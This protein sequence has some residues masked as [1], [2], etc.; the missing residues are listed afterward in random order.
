[1]SFTVG[2]VNHEPTKL[3]PREI[4]A[5]IARINKILAAAEKAAADPAPDVDALAAAR[6]EATAH[7][8]SLRARAA[9]IRAAVTA[10]EAVAKEEPRDGDLA[11]PLAA[12][13]REHDATLRDIEAAERAERDAIR[14]WR[15]AAQLHDARNRRVRHLELHIRALEKELRREEGRPA[16]EGIRPPAWRDLV[17][18]KHR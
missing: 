9:E 16:R 15:E 10:L 2:R 5:E 4:E 14:A 6:A 3:Q 8:V 12:H 11:A 1:M 18:L 17:V 7:H 13:R